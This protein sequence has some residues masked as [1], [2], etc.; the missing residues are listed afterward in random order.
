MKPGVIIAIVVGAVV[1]VGGGITAYVLL[2]KKTTTPTL[3]KHDSNL[4]ESLAALDT[5]YYEGKGAT[6]GKTVDAAG[7]VVSSYL[8][9]IGI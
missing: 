4:A 9:L 7:K 1:V 3:I 5:N 8:N 6:A 2:H